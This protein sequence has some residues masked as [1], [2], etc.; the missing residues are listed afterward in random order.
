V[1]WG[2]VRVGLSKS[3]AAALREQAA[4]DPDA[5]RHAWRSALAFRD[6]LYNMLVA[7]AS[8]RKP[9]LSDLAVVNDHVSSVFRR[10]ALTAS[11]NRFVLATRGAEGDLAPVLEPVVRAAVDLMTSDTLMRLGRCADEICGWLF[12]DA[13]RSRTR[14]WC[15][16]KGC[17]NRNKVGRFR[18]GR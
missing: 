11:K 18:E 12:L 13:T 1:A 17:G 16:M 5:A 3:V 2:E 4:A 14:R 6:A 15:D 7:A 8:R 10:V 9:R